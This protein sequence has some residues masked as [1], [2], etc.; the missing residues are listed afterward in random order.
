MLRS[1]PPEQLYSVILLEHDVMDETQK[2][3]LTN[4]PAPVLATRRTLFSDPVKSVA[5]KW[6]CTVLVCASHLR[7][8]QFY[9]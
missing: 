1:W 3:H 9:P 8:L 5:L 2:T 4:K 6:T 7:Y